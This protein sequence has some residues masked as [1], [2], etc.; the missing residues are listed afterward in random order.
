MIIII[1]YYINTVFTDIVFVTM[2]LRLRNKPRSPTVNMFDFS[3]LNA[4]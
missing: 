1:W 3:D 2:E 4:F